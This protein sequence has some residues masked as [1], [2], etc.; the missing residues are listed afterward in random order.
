M[1][2]IEESASILSE[3]RPR[4]LFHE[5][6]SKHD[7]TGITHLTHIREAPGSRHFAISFGL[8]R[9]FHRQL[10]LSSLFPLYSVLII[11]TGYFIRYY[12]ISV[13]IAP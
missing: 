2:V 5:D 12:I 4:T 7:A 9:P 1:R 11:T 3:I 8:S 13:A 10:P 6:P